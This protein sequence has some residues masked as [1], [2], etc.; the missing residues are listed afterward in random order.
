M[1]WWHQTKLCLFCIFSPL[2]WQWNSSLIWFNMDLCLV[3]IHFRKTVSKFSCS[4]KRSNIF[5]CVSLPTADKGRQTVSL[6]CCPEVK[7]V[8][9]RVESLIYLIYPV[10]EVHRDTEG[11]RMMI[12]I[13]KKGW[14][15]FHSW[16]SCF[17][18]SILLRSFYTSLAIN[19]IFSKFCS[20]IQNL[21]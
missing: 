18:I 15:N 2:Q 21:R 19:G 10:H 3:W 14:K 5:A 12:R 13:S 8:S 9:F 11:Q 1:H 7:Q 16:G 4:D 17:A 20:I 6:P